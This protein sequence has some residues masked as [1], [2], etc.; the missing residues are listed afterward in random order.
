MINQSLLSEHMKQKICTLLSAV[1]MM[2][3]NR[4]KTC[5]LMRLVS[6]RTA[7]QSLELLALSTVKKKKKGWN[8]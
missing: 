2:K 7:L 5:V 1:Q 6:T 3:E 8:N 4:L